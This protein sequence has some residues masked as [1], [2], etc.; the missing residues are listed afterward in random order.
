MTCSRR[1]FLHAGG[2]GLL[3]FTVA[4]CERKLTPAEA[5]KEGA[6]YRTFTEI[7]VAV[8]DALGDS[9]LPGAAA[10]G[11]AHYIDQQLSAPLQDSMLMIKY[12]GVKPPFLEF[13]RSGLAAYVAAASVQF[14]AAPDRLQAEQREALLQQLASGQVADWQG[15]PPGLFY[16]VLRSD[17]VD[18]VYGTPEGFEKLGVPYMPHIAPPSRW[19]T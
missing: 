11:L 4:G 19:D 6:T 15:P 14:T 9:M 17:A 10:A 8:L 18:V 16:F 1:E 12:L 7:E 2:I 13:Y 3:V 5:R